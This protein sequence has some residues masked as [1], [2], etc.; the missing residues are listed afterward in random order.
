M[1]IKNGI[2]ALPGESNPSQVDIYIRRGKIVG[3]IE[4][5]LHDK[6]IGSLGSQRDEL[7]EPII[8]AAGMFV[9]PGAIDPH[10]H[11]DEPGFT[12]REDFLHGTSAAASGGVT[13]IIDM[14]CTSIPPI[15]NLTNLQRKLDIVSKKAVVDY[16]FFGGV[17]SQSFRNGFPDNLGEMAELILGVKTY[18]ISGMKEF[19]QLDLYQLQC[20][21]DECIDYGLPVLIHAEDP[22]FIQSATEFAMKNGNGPNEY[23]QSRP[24]LAEVLAVHSATAIAKELGADLHIVHIS[25]AESCQY[26]NGRNITGETAPQFLEFTLE[27][28]KNMG[29]TLKVTPPVK[30][31]PN[32]SDLWTYLIQS[33]ISFI[34]SD[35]AP[36]PKEQKNTGSIWDDY[37]GIPGTGTM[38]PYIFSEGFLTG[39]LSMEELTN[40]TSFNAAK[41]YGLDDRK[42][43]IAVGKDADFVLIDPSAKWV[44]KGDRFL[45][46]GKVTP[47][48]GYEFNGRIEKTIVRGK[49]VYDRLNGITVDPGY[50]QFLTR[51]ELDYDDI[52]E[53]V[54]DI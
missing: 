37:A 18:L 26:L 6:G 19:G 11:F 54:L 41:R 40:I 39:M 49:I 9:L 20:V 53:E 24:E 47:F 21:L 35:H 45:S 42:G 1:I 8:D 13:T 12:D 44:V 7:D 43:S 32:N 34:A 23:Y 5:A 51:Q 14:P 50:G 25:C 27:D 29:G 46:K 2:V 30:S 4:S 15:T 3:L 17:S 38:L 10:V 48:E 52:E 33:K 31:S 36:A 16:G 28:F 22:S